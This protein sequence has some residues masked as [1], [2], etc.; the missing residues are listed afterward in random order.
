M[1]IMDVKL[2]LNPD[3]SISAYCG[4]ATEA[5]W[6]TPVAMDLSDKDDLEKMGETLAETVAKIGGPVLIHHTI[7]SDAIAMLNWS[8]INSITLSLA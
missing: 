2:A 7:L 1:L 5:F 3:F 6:S 4:S 8:P